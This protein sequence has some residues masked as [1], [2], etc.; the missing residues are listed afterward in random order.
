MAYNYAL[1][2][3]RR[4][5]YPLIAC[6]TPQEAPPKETRDSERLKSMHFYP[7]VD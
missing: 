5:F 3:W 6:C 2:Y 1:A 4:T 7:Q